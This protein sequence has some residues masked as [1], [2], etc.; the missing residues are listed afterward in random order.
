MIELAMANIRRTGAFLLPRFRQVG[1]FLLKQGP[2]MLGNMAYGLL[3]VRALP[4]TDYAMFAV[5]FGFMG[6]LTVLLDIGVSGTL[7]PLVGE[8]IDNLKLIADYLASLRRIMLRLYVIVAPIAVLVFIALLQKQ[9]WGVWVVAQ[10][11]LALLVT[12]W[13][14]RLSSAY[15]AVLILRRDRNYY[16]RTQILGSIG[17]LT[18]LLAFWAMHAINVYVGIL[19]NIGQVAFIAF[20]YFRR[21]HQLLAIKGVSSPQREKS[22]I[23]LAL[24]NA[25]STIFYSIQG[26]ITLALITFFGHNVSSIANV[27]ALTRLSSVIMVFTQMNSILVEPF[28]ARLQAAR[29]KRIYLLAV[30]LVSVFAA[31]ISALAFLFPRVFLWPLGSKYSQLHLE[32]GLIVLSSSIQYVSGFLWVVHSSRRFVYWWN[33]FAIII[34]TVSVQAI[35][36]WKVDLSTVRNVLILNIASALVSFIVIICCGI[37]GFVRGPQKIELPAA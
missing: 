28:F 13:C 3:C 33:N 32:V 23:R 12:A 5:L 1:H 20:S 2:A 16:Y 26:Q 17:S 24:P 10:M 27:G 34:L 11:S 22:I 30:A 36:V 25:P 19:L 18:L 4:K 21:A 35:F 8:Q 15:G 31:T 14:A 9:H 6:S 29:L 37:Y 7:A